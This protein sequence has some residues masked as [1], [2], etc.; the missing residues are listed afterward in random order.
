MSLSTGALVTVAACKTYL[1]KTDSTHDSLLE[2]IVE[3]VTEKFNGYVGRTLGLKT[4]TTYYLDGNGK[5]NLFLPRYPVVSIETVTDDD[6]ELTEGQDED[7]ILS[8]RDGILKR[9]T[10]VWT[11][12]P[13]EVELTNY[14]AGYV[15]Q[16]GTPG[17]GQTALPGDIKLAALM[18]VAA[19]F[20]TYL[21]RDWG[22]ASRTFPD[23]SVSKAAEPDALLAEVRKTLDRYRAFR[24]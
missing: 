3:G 9:L 20:Q 17:T 1:Q 16:D 19:D 7:Y 8:E 24:I 21:K 2:I 22:E 6:D 15:V 12:G 18:Q 5:T 4:D 23:G 13:E 11:Y 14:I 10:G